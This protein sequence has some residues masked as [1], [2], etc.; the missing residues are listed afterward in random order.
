MANSFST[1]FGIQ[2]S[3]NKWCN[4]HPKLNKFNEILLLFLILY[5][6][7]LGRNIIQ[8][9][10]KEIQPSLII[11][12]NQFNQLDPG[13]FITPGKVSHQSADRRI[14]PWQ[15]DSEIKYKCHSSFS[16]Q[17]ILK[18]REVDPR[19]QDLSTCSNLFLPSL[20]DRHS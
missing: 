12:Q 7:E 16:P 15:K 9:K 17:N 2:F 5:P 10:M 1:D 20:K 13:G 4:L 6:S 3:P 18:V 11:V 8:F 19:S 14:R